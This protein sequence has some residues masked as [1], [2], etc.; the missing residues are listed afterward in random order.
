[1]QHAPGSPE[2]SRLNAEL[3]SLDNFLGL[4]ELLEFSTKQRQ[5]LE[6]RDEEVIPDVEC[7]EQY[8]RPEGKIIGIFSK[9]LGPLPVPAPEVEATAEALAKVAPHQLLA[10]TTLACF[11][12]GVT[13]LGQTAPWLLVTPLSV[14][15]LFFGGAS[16][17]A[18]GDGT[19][20]SLVISTVL[21][22]VILA[23]CANT[24]IRKRQ[25]LFDDIDKFAC[26]EEQWFRMGAENWS[27]RQRVVSCF[28]FGACHVFNLFY[29]IVSLLGLSFVG[30]VLM[31]VYLRE[32]KRS[33]SVQLATLASTRLHAVYNRYALTLMLVWLVVT[34]ITPFI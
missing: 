22:V 20:I 2:R 21:N 1:L 29:P 11:M 16:S 34:T 30:G 19:T 28:S 31:F 7:I 25:D 3:E 18:P 24:L 17:H 14:L 13:W 6:E 12:I 5:E 10:I 27:T 15:R 23:F 33:G 9:W 26:R 32:Y 8:T 4:F